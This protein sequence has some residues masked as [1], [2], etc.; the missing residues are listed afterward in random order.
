MSNLKLKSKMYSN[1]ISKKIKS[2]N[3][4]LQDAIVYKC[5][6]EQQK[7]SIILFM[8]AKTFQIMFENLI[9]SFRLFINLKIK[10][11]IKFTFNFRMITQN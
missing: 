3:A 7:N 1:K 5:C 4:C 9:L 11:D 6:H 8:I 10:N 2:M